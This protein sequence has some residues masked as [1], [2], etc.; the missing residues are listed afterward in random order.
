MS[1]LF[2]K[3]AQIQASLRS[4]P[5]SGHNKFHGYSYATAEDIINAVRP[6]CSATGI[7]ISI[8]CI[9]HQI[10]NDGKAASVIVALTATDCETGE[11]TIC[12]MPG[13]AEDV[14]SDKSLWKA[15]TGA[16]KYA[17]RSFFCLASG[18]DPEHA[19]E[20]KVHKQTNSNSQV[21]NVP[22][23]PE[24][25]KAQIMRDHTPEEM[26]E[27]IDQMRRLKW[28]NSD[29]KKFLQENFGCST[30]KELSREQMFAF[31]EYLRNAQTEAGIEIEGEYLVS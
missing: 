21:N 5:E 19:D 12:T 27:T 15:M 22:Q 3:L 2:A 20:E 1:K 4:V 29:G 17:I 7:F 31:L 11:S 10:L 6:I 14:K 9:E 16:T 24:I 25:P 18:D 30:R 13:Y 23:K 8:S 26:Q 28:S